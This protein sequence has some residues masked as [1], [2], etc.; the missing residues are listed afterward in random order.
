MNVASLPA[1]PL[2]RSL[3]RLAVALLASLAL[4]APATV[5]QTIPDLLPGGVDVALGLVDLGSVEDRLAPFLEEAERLDLVAA[6]AAALPAGTVGDPADAAAELPEP[7]T[8]LGVLDLLGREA[9]VFVSSSAFD[10]LPSVTLAAR[11]SPAA[12][13]A[14]ATAIAGA[15]DQPGT[16]RL[17]EAGRTFYTFV[18]EPDDTAG[19]GLPLAYAQA[20]DLLVVSSDPEVVRFILRALEGGDAPR[21]TDRPAW[22][23]LEALG[24][25][26]VLGFLDPLPLTRSLAPLAASSGAQGLLERVQDALSTAGPSVGVLRADDDGLL[27]IGRQR[28]DPAGRDAALYALLSEGTAPTTDVLRFAT[29]GAPAITAGTLNLPGWWAWLNDVTRSAASLGIPT[30]REAAELFDLDV[31]RLLLDWAGDGLVQI[32]TAPLTA[33]EPAMADAPLLGEQVLLLRSR[34]DAAARAGLDAALEQVGATLAGFLD[35]SGQGVR[36]PTRVRIADVP[37]TRLVLSDTLTIDAAVVDGWALLSGSPAATEAVLASYAS[38]G[39]ADALSALAADLPTTARSWSLSSAPST[40]GA[41]A[42]ALIAQLQML[43]GLGGASTL[44]FAAVDRAAEAV[45]AYA[46]FVAERTGPTVAFTV[47]ED[48][49]LTTRQRT[50]LSW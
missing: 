3:R 21:L 12:R 34:D 35:P 43:A 42:D 28:P 13:D 14:F 25:G 9:W 27:S 49:A 30:A 33:T 19:L 8:D 40:D 44:D 11:V 2:G 36:T 29:A 38:G 39:G 10:P 5:A 46:A 26:Q 1:R 6:L 20:D 45:A 4:V 23:E 18:P 41:A 32:Q 16:R 15:D 50:Y 48:G 7:F 24:D 22:A 37:V 47:W 31:D 17:D